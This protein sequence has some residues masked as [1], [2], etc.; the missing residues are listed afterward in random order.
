MFQ[1]TRSLKTVAK[2]SLKTKLYQ[3]TS[4]LARRSY[5]DHSLTFDEHSAQ[6]VNFFNEVDDVYELQRGL[7]NCFSYDLVPSPSVLEAALKASRRVNSYS[8]A[9]R[10]FEGIKDKVDNETQYNEYVKE[11]E[12]IRKQLSILTKEE[13]GL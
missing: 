6:Y 8:T 1:L 7:T 10:I 4:I 3:P 12:P 9:V 13:L 11:L 5:S 2:L